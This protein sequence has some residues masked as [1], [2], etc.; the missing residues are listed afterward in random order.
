MSK[1]PLLAPAPDS[2][3]AF[4]AVAAAAVRHAPTFFGVYDT[5]LRACF[6][7]AAGRAMI[8]LSS[9]SDIAA[10]QIADFF[11]AEDR[12]LVED[13]IVP[14]LLHNGKWS[15]DLGLRHF[16]D[17]AQQT[18]VRWSLFAVRNNAG[19]L[20]SVAALITD[21]SAH[22]QTERLLRDQQVLLASILDNLPLGVGVYDRGGNLNHSNQRMRDYSGLARLPSREPASSQRWRGYDTDGRPIP[23]DGYPGAR[24]LRGEHVTPGMDFLYGGQGS[25]ER[26]M[27]ISAVPFRPQ[28][29]EVDGAIVVVQ[30][31]DDLKRSAERMEAVAAELALQSR[32]VEVTLSS[33][34]DF[35][36]A[37]DRQ[38]RFVYANSAMLS[39]FGLSAHEM[40]GKNFSD[41]HY[42]TELADRLYA[43]MDCVLTEGMTV[44]DEVYYHSPT[45]YGA[46]FDLLW[47]PVRAEDGSIELVVGVSRD[48]TE[49]RA[50]EEA[51]K[52]NE[53]RLRAAT[54]LVGLGVYSWDPVSG[55]L[56][57]DERLRAM[58][59]LPPDAAV[60]KDVFEAGIHRDDVARGSGRD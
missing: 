19:D 14:T 23:P 8:G 22:R 47:G 41:L 36:Y 34:P 27:R 48:T 43:H 29:D 35:V 49:R 11:V 12:A 20:I 30:D 10:Y 32:F 38:H 15:G 44:E 16:T 2:E 52:Q 56:E 50:I 17:L 45:G 5:Q 59:G 7:N 3:G 55:A 53:G 51:L 26:W 33:I 24:A 58:W 25:L 57:W 40:L 28:G 18:E 60:D 6:L 54:E 21:I 1:E 42:P 37:F 9:S 4:S 39:L 46:Y 13:V 31:V